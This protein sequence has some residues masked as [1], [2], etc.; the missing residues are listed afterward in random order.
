MAA[1][2]AEDPDPGWTRVPD[3]NFFELFEDGI[4]RVCLTHK[5]VG[6][7]VWIQLK[8]GERR[9]VLVEDLG[10]GDAALIR[11]EGATWARDHFKLQVCQRDG[12]PDSAHMV[13]TQVPVP[14]LPG[15]FQWC[16]ADITDLKLAHAVGEL[17]VQ[18][19]LRPVEL[20]YGCFSIKKSGW[21][22]M[23][24]VGWIHRQLHRSGTKWFNWIHANWCS[25][26]AFVCDG[27]RLPH[28]ALVKAVETAVKAK[29]GADVSMKP[30]WRCMN[31]SAC[32]LCMCF[33]LLTRWCYGHCAQMGA[34]GDGQDQA[35]LLALWSGL[36]PLFGA[37]LNDW[38]FKD[39]CAVFMQ[40]INTDQGAGPMGGDSN[41]V[42]KIGY[43]SMAGTWNL[44]E[45]FNA[46][47]AQ[48]RTTKASHEL[49]GENGGAF[50]FTL[51]QLARVHKS[52][53]TQSGCALMFVN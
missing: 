7:V 37:A 5:V 10:T 51:P 49:R 30:S 39:N 9:V 36:V 45:Y 24:D 40:G 17:S 26:Q 20:R 27:M 2:V 42:A 15:Q 41:Y 48:G 47:E 33:F 11:D 32:S 52:T 3:A 14:G 28:G 1:D 31:F 44:G 53:E 18:C 4:A 38:T 34:V 50:D 29:D 8:P 25:W 22:T 13:R 43:N 19:G 35:I 23:V 12:E 6:N 16:H 46:L 21:A